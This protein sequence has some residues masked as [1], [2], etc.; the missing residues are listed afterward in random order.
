[1]LD[2]AEQFSFQALGG[3]GEVGMNSMLYRFG[4]L[5]LP[6]DC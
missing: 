1:M 5:L 4:E 6:V 2:K 3:L